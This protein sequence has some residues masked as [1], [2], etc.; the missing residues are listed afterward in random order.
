MSLA[1]SEVSDVTA[2][3]L[4][5]SIRRKRGDSGYLDVVYGRLWLGSNEVGSLVL[6]L[7]RR[8]SRVPGS[9]LLAGWHLNY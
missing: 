8:K 7:A 1:A 2:A 5:C 3:V 9:L 4:I 6:S